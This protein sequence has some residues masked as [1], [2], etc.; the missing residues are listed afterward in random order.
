MISDAA[1][2]LCHFANTLEA[3][4][5]NRRAEI[6]AQQGE[7]SAL[8]WEEHNNTLI[9]AQPLRWVRWVL[10]G[11]LGL[12]VLVVLAATAAFVVVLL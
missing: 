4:Y 11:C 7:A 5:R 1:N 9:A 3:T 12:F 2:A 10:A 6:V 8:A